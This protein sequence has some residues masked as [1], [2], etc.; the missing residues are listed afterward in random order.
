MEI[1][2]EHHVFNR[3]RQDGC[4]GEISMPAHVRIRSRLT[5]QAFREAR[6]SL[7]VCLNNPTLQNGGRRSDRPR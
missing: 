2:P 6:K 3:D 7:T 1:M 4:S 5:D